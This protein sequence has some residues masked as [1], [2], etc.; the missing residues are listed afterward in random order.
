[1]E[2]HYGT[3]STTPISNGQHFTR[4]TL[5]AAIGKAGDSRAGSR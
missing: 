5:G 2:V 1:M 4:G 3:S